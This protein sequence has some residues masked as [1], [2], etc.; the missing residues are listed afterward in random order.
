M[1]SNC[2]AA[3]ASIQIWNFGFDIDYSIT[4]LHT[5]IDQQV[6]HSLQ[7]VFQIISKRAY[8]FDILRNHVLWTDVI[9]VHP[10][11]RWENDQSW[12]DD[13]DYESPLT[14]RHLASTLD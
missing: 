4:T 2:D 7:R 5:R 14:V 9:A 6:I 12:E 3:T 8:I 10:S 11:S 13:Q 1:P